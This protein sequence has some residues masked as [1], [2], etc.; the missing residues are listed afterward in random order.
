MTL[1]FKNEREILMTDA[2]RARKFLISFREF[3]LSI[4]AAAGQVQKQ[5]S[6][7]Y[8]NALSKQEPRAGPQEKP[9][10]A[11]GFYQAFGLPKG[12]PGYPTNGRSNQ[13]EFPNA[14]WQGHCCTGARKGF[15]RAKQRKQSKRSKEQI[16]ELELYSS[17]E[18][19]IGFP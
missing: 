9:R 1:V 10:R 16:K 8:W 14:S 17:L 18:K 6:T 2:T 5:L 15:K 11:I 4:L 7:S 12:G 13:E 3:C 19:S